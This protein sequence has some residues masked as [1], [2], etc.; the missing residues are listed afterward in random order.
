MVSAEMSIEVGTLDVTTKREKMTQGGLM[1]APPILQKIVLIVLSLALIAGGT[2]GLVAGQAP[3]SYKPAELD[4]L[5]ARIALYPDPL[6]AQIL[7]AATYPDQIPDAAKWADDHHYLRGDD[8]ARAIAA[9]HLIWDP[10]VQAL[11]PFPS[12]LGMM[13]SDMDWTTELGNAFLAQQQ[14]VMDAVQRMRK[15]A[16]EYGYLRSNEQVVVSGDP[17]ITIVPANPT[18]IVVPVYDPLIVFA[19]PAPGFFVGGAI[20][21]GYGVTLGFAFR[22]W[23]WGTTRFVWDRHE[24][25]IANVRWERTWV[26]RGSYVHH[27]AAY[28]PWTGARG[29]ER[30]ELI[31]RSEAERNAARLGHARVPEVHHSA[32]VHH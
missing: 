12:V 25:F 15:K 18:F 4:K 29:A 9:D 13:A 19:P 17:Y 7:A 28:H 1:R 11:L 14:D 20:V 26:N 24:V 22:P 6:L 8:L 30:H 23:G 27:F 16:K 5:V 21:F 31:P 10:S 3:L 32:P 2:P